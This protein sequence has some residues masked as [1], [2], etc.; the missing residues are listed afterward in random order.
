MKII[1]DN[2]KDENLALI[3]ELSYCLKFTVEKF[4]APLPIEK[5]WTEVDILDITDYNLL[6]N[7]LK[8]NE[9]LSKVSGKTIKFYESRLKIFDEFNDIV[10]ILY[11]SKS[12]PYRFKRDELLF[13]SDAI[14]TRNYFVMENGYDGKNWLFTLKNVMTIDVQD[15]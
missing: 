1:L 13:E 7:N 12:L 5:E 11:Y 4:E 6:G 2:L 9:Y 8:F 14:G 15:Y 3:H 10:S